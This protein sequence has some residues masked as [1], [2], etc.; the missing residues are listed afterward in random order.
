MLPTDSWPS[1][2]TPHVSTQPPEMEAS[3]LVSCFI[4]WLAHRRPSQ[5]SWAWL[6]FHRVFESLVDCWAKKQMEFASTTTIVVD[7][8]PELII[9]Y[10]MGPVLMFPVWGMS[11][12]KRWQ[13]Q[14]SGASLGHRSE[15]LEA[16]PAASKRAL[17]VWTK[18]GRHVCLIS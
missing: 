5:L 2:P 9:E 4:C 14:W 17:T 12:N 18:T 11:A 13:Q 16:Y 10:S 6:S 15:Y 8:D 3:L 7:A 1:S